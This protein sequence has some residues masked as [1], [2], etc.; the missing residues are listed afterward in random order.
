[1]TAIPTWGQLIRRAWLVLRQRF[2]RTAPA[3][4]DCGWPKRYVHTGIP[5]RPYRWLC[6]SCNDVALEEAE[7][8]ERIQESMRMPSFTPFASSVRAEREH[9]QPSGTWEKPPSPEGSAIAIAN[10]AVSVFGQRLPPPHEILFLGLPRSEQLEIEH[11]AYMATEESE[12]I[13]F[14]LKALDEHRATQ[15]RRMEARCSIAS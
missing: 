2:Q 5:E 1:M 4:E 11:A 12:S 8:R 10:S 13:R 7:E 15:Q 9:R 14:V 3:C 6:E